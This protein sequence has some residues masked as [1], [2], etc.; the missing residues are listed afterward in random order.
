MIRICCTGEWRAYEGSVLSPVLL[1]PLL[2]TTLKESW[3][4]ATLTRHNALPSS[5]MVTNSV[6]IG[7]S[8]KLRPRHIRTGTTK[9]SLQS[10]QQLSPLNGSG[11][12]PHPVIA[13]PQMEHSILFFTYTPPR[14]SP[15]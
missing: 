1:S 7:P 14:I 5:A 8:L 2:V 6:S 3:F 4:A 13:S 12:L 10:S 15:S 9:R 11:L